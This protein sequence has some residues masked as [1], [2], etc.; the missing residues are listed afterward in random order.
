MSVDFPADIETFVEQE[1]S[2]GTYASREELIVAAVTLLRQRQADL[3]RLREDIAEGLEGE[4][5]PAAQIFAEL[6]AKFGPR[7]AS[8]PP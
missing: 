6:R 2:S 4:G 8:S 3:E 5:I 7:Q 1:V